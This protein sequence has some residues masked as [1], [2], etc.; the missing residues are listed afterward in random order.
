[1]AVV[2]LLANAPQ[3]TALQVTPLLERSYIIDAVRVTG[4]APAYR[5]V[6][7]T[8]ELT[9]TDS[10]DD[11]AGLPS[12][13][14]PLH[15][16]ERERNTMKLANRILLFVGIP[17]ERIV[18]LSGLVAILSSRNEII[19]HHR[20][21]VAPRSGTRTLRDAAATLDRTPSSPEYG[22]AVNK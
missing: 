12:P 1:M 7:D 14:Q 19:G 10:A 8:F 15:S 9:V 18:A 11:K 2:P 3:P 5:V 6:D 22:S 20:I 13:P 21:A 16:S 17:I 4:E